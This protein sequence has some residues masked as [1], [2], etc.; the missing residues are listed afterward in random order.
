[1]SEEIE[2]RLRA[3]RVGLPEPSVQAKEIAHDRALAASAEAYREVSG[4]HETEHG[5]R[6]R[7]RP[8]WKGVLRRRWALA[9]LVCTA[10]L[11]LAV[12]AIGAS[13]LWP[14]SSAAQASASRYPGPIFTPAEGWTTM[15]T[16]GW[17]VSPEAPLAWA[18]NIAVSA[19]FERVYLDETSPLRNLPSDGI[20]ILASLADPGRVP[21]PQSREGTFVDRVLPLQIS[22]AEIQP[23]WLG[24][25]NP[26]VPQ[27]LLLSRVKEQWVDVRIYFGTQEPSD[28]L[29]SAAQE[30]LRRLTIPDPA[31]FQ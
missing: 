24:Q 21:A 28:A 3:S 13:L 31:V 14:G 29:R 18:T 2:E 16:S 17:P 8:A 30:Q 9:V 22:D 10:L 23:T 1:M 19:D 25:P 5:I 6:R 4:T 15:A 12:G 11:S 27:Y 7:L 20:F 26:E